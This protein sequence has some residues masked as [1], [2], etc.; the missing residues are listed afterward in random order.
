MPDAD[1]LWALLERAGFNQIRVTREK[2]PLSFD[3]AAQL[4]STLAASPIRADLDT[5][6]APRREQLSH[7]LERSV[8]VNDAL[9]AEAVANLAFAR[10]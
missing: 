5:L 8:A 7:A 9:Q 2:L 6:P 3:S 4:G 1:R 10:W